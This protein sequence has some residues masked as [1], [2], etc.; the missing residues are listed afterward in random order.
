MNG[1]KIGKGILLVGC[2]MALCVAAWL[3]SPWWVK[4]EFEHPHG[5]IGDILCLRALSVF[6]TMV[7]AMR[8]SCGVFRCIRKVPR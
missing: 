4:S 6:L 5:R 3:Y 1:K 2:V 7:P 8:I